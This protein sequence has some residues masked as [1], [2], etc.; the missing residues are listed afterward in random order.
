MRAPEWLSRLRPSAGSADMSFL[1]HLEELRSV[2]LSCIGILLL[3]TIG[4]WFLS[5]PVL[6]FL[7]AH[8][9]ERA[10]FIKPLEAFTTRLKLAFL[11]GFIAG[12][13]FIAF[14]L[15]SFIVP[16]LLK[17]ERRL[18]MPL[19]VWSQISGVMIP[20]TS[21]A[22]MI[23]IGW[24]SSYPALVHCV[25]NTMIMTDRCRLSISGPGS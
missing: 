22:M 21:I 5:G 12:L 7:V 8:T 2:L 10:Q 9:I 6:D 16:G 14:R 13:P 15:W 4:G 24:S 19:V 17:H 20:L 1:D 11:M 25:M 23:V 3:L 18:V